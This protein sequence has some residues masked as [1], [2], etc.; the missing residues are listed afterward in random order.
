MMNRVSELRAPETVLEHTPLAD[1]KSN[2][3]AELAV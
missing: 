2:S 1:S 3:R